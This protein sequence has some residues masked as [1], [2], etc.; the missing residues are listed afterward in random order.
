[1]QKE[2]RVEEILVPGERSFRTAVTN[3]TYGVP[4]AMKR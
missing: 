3:A 4:S 2:A 1:M